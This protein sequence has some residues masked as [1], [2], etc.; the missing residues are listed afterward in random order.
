[1]NIDASALKCP[2]QKGANI[3]LYE[4]PGKIGHEYVHITTTT[5]FEMEERVTSVATGI[6]GPAGGSSTDSAQASS[7]QSGDL[8]KV[9]GLARKRLRCQCDGKVQSGLVGW[10]LNQLVREALR[11]GGRYRV[12][13][14]GIEL[15]KGFELCQFVL[16]WNSREVASRLNKVGADSCEA[17]SGTCSTQTKGAHRS[18]V[19]PQDRRYVQPLTVGELVIDRAKVCFLSTTDPNLPAK[20]IAPGCKQLMDKHS[21]PLRMY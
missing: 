6:R 9:L 2:F 7:D 11:L 15:K 3:G 20:E 8:G 18:G 12:E 10:E 5:D 21:K 4:E 13:D 16:V 14:L 17:Q 1:M 19:P